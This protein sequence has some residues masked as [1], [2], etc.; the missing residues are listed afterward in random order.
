MSIRS[1]SRFL[2]AFGLLAAIAA[3]T[4]RST[5]SPPA[6]AILPASDTSPVNPFSGDT[7]WIAY[8]TNRGGSEGI[9]LIHPDGTGD[10]RIDAGGLVVLLPD[11]SPDGRHI[12]VA[13]RGG[14][15]E[16]LFE[17]DLE[18]KTFRQ[19]FAC[20]DPCLGDD[21]PA[22]S[23]DRQRVVFIRA[24]LPFTYSEVMGG[25]VPGDCGLWIGEISTGIVDQITS[26]PECDREYRPRWSPDGTQLVYWRNPYDNG[27]PAGTAVYI[28]NADGTNERRLTDP[29]MFAGEADWSPD[30]EWIVF[31]TYPLA[32]FNFASVVSNLYRIHPDGAGLEQLTFFESSDFR[33]TQPGYSPDGQW[34]IF[35]LVTPSSRSLWAIPAQG[36]DPVVIAQGGIYTHAAWQP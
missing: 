30:G 28:I 10:Q 2:G 4:P 8:Q 34:I 23:P 9:W 33:A 12:A 18:S 5:T 15:T 31:D 13:S 3:C 11:W 27:R 29:P 7:S 20:E 26:N 19:L 17:Y 22:Y 25:D 21:E 32:E 1:V 16:P 6:S 36:G 35:T 24:L 14:E